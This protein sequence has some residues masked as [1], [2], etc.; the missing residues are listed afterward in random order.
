MKDVTILTHYDL[1]LFRGGEKFVINLANALLEIGCNVTVL[2][3]PFNKMGRVNPR[4]YLSHKVMYKYILPHEKLKIDSDT[5]YYIYAPIIYELN[6]LVKDY[7]HLKIAGIH[8]FVITAELSDYE[9]WRIPPLR[10]IRMH[11]FKAFLA[12]YYLKLTGKRD[13]FKYDLIHIINPFQRAFLP[14]RLSPRIFYAPLWTNYTRIH[15]NYTESEEY[16]KILIL[17]CNDFR[18]G[19]DI[20]EALINYFFKQSS[21]KILFYSNVRFKNPG[22]RF[23]GFIKEEDIPRL[24]SQVNLLLHPSRLD[25]FGLTIIESLACGTPVITSNILAHRIF[26]PPVF[27]CSS[28]RD[29]IV[30]ITRLYGLW[31]EGCYE[32]VRRRAESEGK[33]FSK[34]SVLPLY[35]RLFRC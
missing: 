29:Y 1:S 17:G 24:L 31:R 21:F 6:P 33:K 7:S 23:I 22:V 20:C 10:F 8:G 35:R 18:K 5:S 27:L 4:R 25:T 26:S 13:L 15:S 2:A 11:G 34:E 9:V 30:E 14:P 3:Y 16:F 28:L 19:Y 12:Y 32:E